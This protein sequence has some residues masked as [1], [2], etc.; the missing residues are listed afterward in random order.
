MEGNVREIVQVLAAFKGRIIGVAYALLVGMVS[1]IWGFWDG[2]FLALCLFL[3][4]FV[5]KRF[6]HKDSLRDIIERILPPSD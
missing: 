1:A 5:G 4:Y 3:G 2:A 6:D